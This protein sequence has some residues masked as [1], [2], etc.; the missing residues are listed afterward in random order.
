MNLGDRGGRDRF[1]E[2]LEHLFHRPAELLGNRRCRFL[3]GKRRQPVLEGGQFLRRLLADHVGARGQKLAELDVGGPSLLRASERRSSALLS[4]TERRSKSAPDRLERR[5][6]PGGRSG[7]F[8]QP[9]TPSRA[10]T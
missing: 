6:G 10:I 5:R 4:R 2:L 1:T 7:R 8:D 3:M 9:K